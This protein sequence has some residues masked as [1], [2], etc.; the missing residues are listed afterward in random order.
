MNGCVHKIKMLNDIKILIKQYMYIFSDSNF[1]ETL[2]PP[3]GEGDRQQLR[4]SEAEPHSGHTGLLPLTLTTP[5]SRRTRFRPSPRP[6]PRPFQR[7]QTRTHLGHLQ[8]Q[9]QG[10]Q[11][12][13]TGQRSSRSRQ[14]Q[15]AKKLPPQRPKLPKVWGWCHPH[16]LFLAAE[17][18]AEL[19]AE[20]LAGFML[21]EELQAGFLL[22]TELLEG[23]SQWTW[24]K[25]RSLCPEQD[26]GLCRH[27]HLQTL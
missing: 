9:L 14:K 20:Q 8:E 19:L 27:L 7:Y 2:T 5:P 6:R 11:R 22:T 13:R 10:S 25:K 24:R 15:H 1:S 12:W 18:L 17:L 23:T 4:Q 26:T 3:S 21:T 16:H